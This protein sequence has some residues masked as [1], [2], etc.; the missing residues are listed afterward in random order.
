MKFSYFQAVF[1]SLDHWPLDDDYRYCLCTRPLRCEDLERGTFTKFKS[2]KEAW[3]FCFDG[4][5]TVAEA[6]ANVERFE[7]LPEHGRKGSSSDSMKDFKFGHAPEDAGDE[8]L[9][10]HFP[11]EANT[12]IKVKTEENAIGYFAKQYRDADHEYGMLIDPQGFV[13]SYSEG[14]ATAVY[15]GAKK[16]TFAVHNHPGGGAFSDA[17]LINTARTNR[18]GIAAIGKGGDYYFRKNGGHFR[19][20]EFARAVKNARLRGT[21]YD[22]AVRRWLRANQKKYGYTFQFVKQK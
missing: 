9:P 11:A 8:N 18:S 1:P 4:I 2:L 16:G 6:F 17:D 20:P 5:R 3:D 7:L 12:R 10:P 21:D 22:D 13:H 15:I 14:G 19:G